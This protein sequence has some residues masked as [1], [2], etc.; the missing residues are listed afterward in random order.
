MFPWG[1]N[2]HLTQPPDKSSTASEPVTNLESAPES[3]GGYCT[4]SAISFAGQLPSTCTGRP[5][6]FGFVT[7]PR[8]RMALHKS[9]GIGL[10]VTRDTTAHISRRETDTTRSSD[11]L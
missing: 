5:R 6:I 9:A 3:A 11:S 1:V 4:T 10:S 8:V 2:P 7:E